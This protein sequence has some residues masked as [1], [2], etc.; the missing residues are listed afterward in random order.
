MEDSSFGRLIGV[1]VSPGKTFR[2]IAERP[3]WLV[4]FLVLMVLSLVAKSMLAWQVFSGTLRP[5]G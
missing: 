1:L 4:P 3:A 5:G 2:S